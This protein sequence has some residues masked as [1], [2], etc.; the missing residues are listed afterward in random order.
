M[1][2][3]SLK[4]T[5]QENMK[6]AMRSG[7]KEKL[8][9]IRLMLASIK[10]REVDE[11]I[12]LNNEQVLTVLDKM[13]KQRRESIAQYEKA[14]RIDLVAKEQAEIDVI[15]QYL[16]PQFSDAEIKTLIESAIKETGATGA[17]DMGKV[18]ALLKPQLQSRA[19]IGAVSNAVKERLASS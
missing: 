11:R 1:T 3:Q 12:V 6:N 19:D 15:M 7:E 17:R 8:A 16:P 5:I 10:Q 9:T 4:E 18:M 2:S 13:I 14:S